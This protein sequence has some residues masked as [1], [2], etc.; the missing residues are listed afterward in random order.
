MVVDYLTG[1]LV[2][3]YQI[4]LSSTIGFHGIAKKIVI[5]CLVAIAHVVDAKII[6]NGSVVRTAVI[7]FYIN[8]EGISVLENA[9]V[10]GLPVPKKLKDV[11]EQIKDKEDD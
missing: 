5:F 11:L 7:F 4:K 10:L 8:N 2:A 1:V 6:Q 3:V 9:S